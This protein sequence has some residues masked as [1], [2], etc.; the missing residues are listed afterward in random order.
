ML[1]WFDPT[2]AQLFP[3]HAGKQERLAHLPGFRN[4]KLERCVGELWVLVLYLDC[5]KSGDLA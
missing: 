5:N 4:L 3:I 2:E 1:I